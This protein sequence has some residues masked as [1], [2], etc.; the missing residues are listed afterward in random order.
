MGIYP[1]NCPYCH[2]GIHNTCM[3]KDHIRI[4]HTGI[5]GYHCNRCRQEFD[6]VKQLKAHLEQNNCVFLGGKGDNV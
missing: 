4:H 5:L 3:L 1:Y 2:K 6:N